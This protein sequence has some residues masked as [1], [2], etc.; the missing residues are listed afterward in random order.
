MD[1]S[2][3][4][5]QNA[6]ILV[7]DL[8]GTLIDTNQA[9]LLAYQAATL[10]V[11]GTALPEQAASYD[12]LTRNRLQEALDDLPADLLD[13]IVQRKEVLY[14][15]FLHTTQLN[16]KLYQLLQGCQDKV[17]VLATNARQARAEQLLHQHQ[18]NLHHLFAECYYH[19]E[20]Q[21]NKFKQIFA[22]FRG[23]EIII[24]E[25]EAAQASLALAAGAHPHN[26]IMVNAL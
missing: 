15:Q 23:K 2:L 6:E 17:L 7:V 12:R 14:P 5:I 18:H 9:N 21:P 13:A 20:G 1:E 16:T 11:T 25:N 4:K 3:L 24:F 10:E 8:D 22:R 26:I 19:G